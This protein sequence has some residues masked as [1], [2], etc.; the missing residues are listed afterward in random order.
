MRPYG[1]PSVPYSEFVLLRFPGRIVPREARAR[2]PTAVPRRLAADIYAMLV[3]RL[4]AQADASS[5][6]ADT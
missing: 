4:G 1:W 5:A 2:Q 6:G 3:A